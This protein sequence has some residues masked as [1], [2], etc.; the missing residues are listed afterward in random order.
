MFV[1]R[2][3]T[4]V[5][6][7]ADADLIQFTGGADVDPSYYGDVKHATTYSDPTRDAYEANLF[8]QE[9]GK[10]MAGIC[11][12]G[13]F[14]NVMCGG[15]LYQNVNGHMRPH[16]AFVTH[17]TEEVEVS[18]DHHQMMVPIYPEAISLLI[19]YESRDIATGSGEWHSVVP[20]ED[21]EAVYYADKQCLCFQPHPEYFDIGHRCQELYFEMLKEYL[22]VEEN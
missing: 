16:K 21:T 4:V 6:N 8:N 18:S 3:W 12:G 19:A 20:N 13:Q 5:N 15:N 11:R 17:T 14:L 9:I 7:T 10:P 2:G 22:G 1:K